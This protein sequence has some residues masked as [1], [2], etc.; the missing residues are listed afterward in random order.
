[1]EQGRERK[2]HTPATIFATK[3]RGFPSPFASLT[4]A[5][6]VF[7]VRDE[8]MSCSRKRYKEANTTPKTRT[9]TSE[10]A[11]RAMR[12]KNRVMKRK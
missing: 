4:G 8:P 11:E 3:S 1:M 6:V 5:A 9:I 10:E 7:D 12:K 2:R